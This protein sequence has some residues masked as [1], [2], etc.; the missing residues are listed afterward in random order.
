MSDVKLFRTVAIGPARRARVHRDDRRRPG[1]PWR[2]YGPYVQSRR[3]QIY[4]SYVR[5]LLRQGRAYPCFA[6][7]AQLAEIAGQQRAAGALP[8][9]CG[10][11][12]VWR[13]APAEHGRRAPC[14][15]R[16]S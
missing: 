11:W 5:E 2:A 3:A 16:P 1:P 10:Q 12:A 13:D 9:Y 8:G 15:G 7:R 14:R 6:T 4:L